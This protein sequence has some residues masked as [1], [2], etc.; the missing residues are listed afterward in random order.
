MV[1]LAFWLIG[2]VL[3][4]KGAI[5]IW[6]IDAS[7][8]KKMLAVGVLVLTSWIGLFFYDFYARRRISEWL[9][10]GNI[11]ERQKVIRITSDYLS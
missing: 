4:F 8:E 5:K 2:F 11:P 10:R 1:I 9:Q 3:T 6:N 7:V